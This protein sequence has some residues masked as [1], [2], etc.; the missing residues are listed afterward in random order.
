[1]PLSRAQWSGFEP[2]AMPHKRIAIVAAMPIE[3]APLLGSIRPQQVDGVDLY[4]LPNA[5]VAIGGMGAKFARHA[6]EVVVEQAKPEQLMSAGMAGA[7]SPR[8]KVGDVGRIRE[9]VDV[10][11]GVRYPAEAEGDWVLATSQDVSDVGEKRQLFIK[12]SAEVV[13]M[14]AAAVAQVALERGLQ[15]RAIKSIS[16]GAEL[17]LPPMTQFI[18]ERGRFATSRFLMYVASRPKWWSVLAKLRENT[19]IASTNLCREL[20]HLI[21]VNRG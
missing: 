16:D 17:S 4:E 2:T 1:M 10:A 12:C 14:E 9:V 6:A 19:K 20:E 18:D 8:L 21:S 13:D 5:M 11:T 15:F 3:L 7:T